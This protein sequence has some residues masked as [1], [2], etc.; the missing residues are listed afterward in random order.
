[1]KSMY[2]V[3]IFLTGM[4][5]LS[6][7]VIAEPLSITADDNIESVLKSNDGKQVTVKLG[8]GDELTGTIGTVNGK[9]V[10]LRELSG[11]EFFDAVV[12]MDN[13]SAIIIRTKK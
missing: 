7:A 11:K 1:M 12:S 10:H 9:L 6:S 5:L 8:S 4:L 13:I 2:S 3:V